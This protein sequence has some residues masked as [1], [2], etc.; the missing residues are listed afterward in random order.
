MLKICGGEWKGRYLRVPEGSDT[1]PTSAFLRESIFNTL[2]NSM[3][4]EPQNVL[5]LF[6][7]SGALGFEAL[8][9]GAQRAVFVEAG[10]KAIKSLEKN[11]S[12]LAKQKNTA[13]LRDKEFKNWQKLLLSM[14][15]F[16]PID[17]VF[18]D[19]PYG[20]SLISKSLSLLTQEELW[21]EEV[22]LVAEM[23][24]NE[25]LEAVDLGLK[26]SKIKEKTQGDSKVAFFQR[27]R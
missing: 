20:K 17:L 15:S 3:G 23:A 19:P 24:S 1:R 7:G 10:P 8:S 9:R 22:I 6:A 16:L 18:C 25:S 13:L 11:V 26:W 12:E 21:A 2:Q 14:K 5:D 27:L 4:L